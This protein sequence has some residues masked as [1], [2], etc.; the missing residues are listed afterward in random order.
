MAD[1]NSKNL[2]GEKW[3]NVS[4]NFEHT[5][6][7]RLEVSNLGR[8]R[9]F[10]KLSDGNVLNGSLT[11]GYKIIRLKFFKPTEPGDAKKILKK[12]KQIAAQM[13]DIKF[14]KANN[15]KKSFLK[16]EEEELL[17]FKKSLS[18]LF[19]ENTKKRTINYHSLFHRLVAYYFL[20]K[21]SAGKTIVSH[22][23]HNKLNNTVNNL[24]WM[25]IKDNSVH[26]QFSPH[27]IA[28]KQNRMYSGKG[29]SRTTKLTVTKVM[30][31][32]K[33]LNEGK[34]VKQMV[35]QFKVSDMQIIRIRRGE[36]WGSIPAAK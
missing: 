23:D 34:T 31:L 24:E 8:V 17:S 4:F 15:A 10:N 19:A 5:N 35:K 13:Q 25:T 27:V 28:E 6:H 22:L 1:T 7:Y 18:K 30:L 29:S 33:L 32:K 12:Q 26:Q 36:N 21:P 11:E 9:S 16:E 2:Y 3:K 20:P 14:L